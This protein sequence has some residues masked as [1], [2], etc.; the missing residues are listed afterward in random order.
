MLA[1]DHYRVLLLVGGLRQVGD[2]SLTH[3]KLPARREVG[4]WSARSRPGSGQRCIKD[5]LTFTL[6]VGGEEERG[7]GRNLLEMTL[8]F[9]Q[10]TPET[11]QDCFETTRQLG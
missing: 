4:D 3:L 10:K 1:I 2:L 6:V 11:E 8:I 9:S 5:L 7:R